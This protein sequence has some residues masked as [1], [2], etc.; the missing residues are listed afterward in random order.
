M[1]TP[2]PGMDNVGGPAVAGGATE[3]PAG[4]GAAGPDREKKLSCQASQHRI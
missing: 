1:T 4:V 3:I 2:G